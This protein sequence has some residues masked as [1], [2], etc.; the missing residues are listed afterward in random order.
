MNA[1][2]INE[3]LQHLCRS[4]AVPIMQ[5]PPRTSASFF[6][7]LAAQGGEEAADAAGVLIF[8]GQFS[9]REN[10][11]QPTLYLAPPTIGGSCRLWRK[12]PARRLLRVSFDKDLTHE[13]AS[14][15]RKHARQIRR[16]REWIGKPLLHLGDCFLS[17]GGS[18][19]SPADSTRT[20]FLGILYRVFYAKEGT[21]YFWGE[22]CTPEIGEP[23]PAMPLFDFLDQIIPV[24]S[25]VNDGMT[26]AK[27]SARVKLWL[28][29]TESRGS[30]DQVRWVPDLTNH[31]LAIGSE[32]LAQVCL[33]LGLSYVPSKSPFSMP[34]DHQLTAPIRLY[35]RRGQW[36]A[37]YLGSPERRA[38]QNH[39]HQ[40]FWPNDDGHH[41]RGMARS[42]CLYLNRLLRLRRACSH[43]QKG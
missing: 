33:A 13:L 25:G 19:P 17:L 9:L 2:Q 15:E 41:E 21:L 10:D 38:L 31:T 24:L 35:R 36:G 6:R 1:Q 37:L 22:S 16:F 40:C 32:L 39:L 20:S 4:R 18:S 14:S 34:N 29:K 26:L 42:S 43:V 11:L 12:Y 3:E 28:S 23:F 5:I 30:I 27:L 8:R 7:R